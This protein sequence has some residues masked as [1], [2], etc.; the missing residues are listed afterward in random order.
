MERPAA[1]L[2]YNPLDNWGLI[3]SARKRVPRLIGLRRQ[4]QTVVFE[5][6]AAGLGRPSGPIR[7]GRRD[8]LALIAAGPIQDSEEIAPSRMLEMKG[9]WFIFNTY[10]AHDDWCRWRVPFWH[11]TRVMDE[12]SHAT[13]T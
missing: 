10:R 7:P 11:G 9:S 4:S 12:K 8:G 5:I 3:F 1:R 2:Y 13:I 6:D